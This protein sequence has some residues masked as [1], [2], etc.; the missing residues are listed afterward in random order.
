M[1]NRLAPPAPPH[2]TLTTGDGTKL[3]VVTGFTVN[4]RRIYPQLLDIG[5]V[6][7]QPMAR[8]A[9]LRL[10]GL[11]EVEEPPPARPRF[12]PAVILPFDPI[13]SDPLPVEDVSD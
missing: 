9:G 13:W 1:G 4:P 6:S 10:Y 11:S 3:G 12:K 2:V 7:V 5:Q 8:P